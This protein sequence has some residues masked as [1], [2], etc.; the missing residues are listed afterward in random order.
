MPPSF[1]RATRCEGPNHQAKLLIGGTSSVLGEASVHVGNLKAQ[2]EETYVN[3]DSLIQAGG[4]VGLKSLESLRIYHIRPNDGDSLLRDALRRLPHLAGKIE[5]VHL[6][7]CREDL[8][9]E[10]EGVARVD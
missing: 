1:A 2:T 10:I 7:L 9:V 3:I 5:L 4:G 6:P 8:L